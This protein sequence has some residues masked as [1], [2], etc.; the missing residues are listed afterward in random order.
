[1][2]SLLLPRSVV[3]LVVRFAGLILVLR[4]VFELSN[5]VRNVKQKSIKL[6]ERQSPLAFPVSEVQTADITLNFE[7]AT[8]AAAKTTIEP[9]QGVKTF[10]DDV[11]L[12]LLDLQANRQFKY[13]STTTRPRHD[14]V[15]WHDAKW[16][17]FRD[18]RKTFFYQAV[19]YDN[20]PGQ[21][22]LKVF[23]ILGV[24][25]GGVPV[26]D[27]VYAL[28]WYAHSEH[29]VSV[30]VTQLHDEW[31]RQ[32]YTNGT[33]FGNAVQTV[34]ALQHA[35][36]DDGGSG[37][38]PEF[39]SFSKQQCPGDVTTYLQVVQ[40]PPVNASARG[41]LVCPKNLY[42]RLN[43]SHVTHFVSW[44]EF[45]KLLGVSRVHMAYSGLELQDEMIRRMFR[46]YIDEGT[47]QNFV[48]SPNNLFDR[49][50]HETD[51]VELANLNDCLYR[52]L[53]K[54]KYVISQDADELLIPRTPQT[55][56]QLI[57]THIAENPRLASVSGWRSFAALHYTFHPPGN[58]EQPWYVPFLRMT[59]RQPMSHWRLNK[60]NP[61]G[62]KVIGV[63]SRIINVDVHNIRAFRGYKA[64]EHLPPEKM[65]VH[66]YRSGCR[67]LSD[68][69][70]Q[71]EINEAFRDDLIVQNFANTT[72]PRIK[73]VLSKLDYFTYVK[74]LRKEKSNEVY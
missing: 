43:S 73:N 14:D 19:Y 66:H 49:N 48:Y 63:M 26:D 32:R 17:F 64:N 34:D 51:G 69:E 53:H 55:Y 10:T 62:S 8:T 25:L 42:G 67:R 41:I 28:L 60:K 57:A 3:R 71:K 4:L 56:Q 16:Q 35:S 46:Y 68:E 7:T 13:C 61:G 50:V 59:L 5:L 33:I 39:V 58:P 20:R 2:S 12:A 27:D 15:L 11:I 9:E 31:R 52:N 44:F 45:L 22:N 74:R 70:C 1:M 29:P 47:L 72:I 54:Y 30:K 36:G 65:L 38:R 40:P 21:H 23:P 37:D 18:G 6:V 24:P